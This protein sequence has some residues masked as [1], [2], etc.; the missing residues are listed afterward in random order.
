MELITNLKNLKNQD[1]LNKDEI[2]KITNQE[3]ILFY[4]RE[5]FLNNQPNYASLYSVFDEIREIL[6]ESKDFNTFNEFL[7]L[8]TNYLNLVYN[9]DV[10]LIEALI[11]I[12]SPVY[13]DYILLNDF[14][15]QDKFYEFYLNRYSSFKQNNELSIMKMFNSLDVSLLGQEGDKILA[16]A[17][18]LGVEVD[19]NK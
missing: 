1:L 18:E 15:S 9:I 3:S 19:L 5:K 4:I 12:T 13:T 2:L 6:I 7:I 16:V 14:L 10:V 8:E 11:Y 17:K